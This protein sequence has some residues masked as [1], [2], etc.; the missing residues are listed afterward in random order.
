MT[1]SKGSDGPSCLMRGRQIIRDEKGK[2]GGEYKK[3]QTP[4][5]L[6]KL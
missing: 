3:S 6:D 5:R 4:G 2:G 1:N